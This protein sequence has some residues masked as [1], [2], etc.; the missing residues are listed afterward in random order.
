MWACSHIQSHNEM[1]PERDNPFVLYFL[2]FLP[3]KRSSTPF[4]LIKI[5]ATAIVN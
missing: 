2:F 4:D 1:I 3:L 5:L